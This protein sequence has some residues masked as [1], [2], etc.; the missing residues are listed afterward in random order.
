MEVVF[1]S[2]KSGNTGEININQVNKARPGQIMSYITVV[3]PSKCS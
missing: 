3:S 1:L 2:E